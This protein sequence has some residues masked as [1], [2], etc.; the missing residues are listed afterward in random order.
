[1]K[2]LSALALFLML[3]GP[4]LGGEITTM[5]IGEYDDDHSRETPEGQTITPI[6]A[7]AV[8]KDEALFA[9]LPQHIKEYD[10]AEIRWYMAGAVPVYFLDAQGEV[11]AGLEYWAITKPTGGFLPIDIRKE[12]E[13][14]VKVRA[15][16]VANDA[17]KWKGYLLPQLADLIDA[18]LPKG[19]FSLGQTP[20]KSD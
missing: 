11:V 5:V 8:V 16:H 20:K 4:A 14:F 1:M 13:N 6:K 3:L 12:G 15:T 9:S 10:P 7:I 18:S 17:E 19:Y 2:A